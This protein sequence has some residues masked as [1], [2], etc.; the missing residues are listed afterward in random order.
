MDSMIEKTTI[1]NNKKV[2]YFHDDMNSPNDF[3]YQV[4]IPLTKN[5]IGFTK[6]ETTTIPPFE[7][8][9]DILFFDWGG[10]SL[11]NSMLNHFCRHI[12]KQAFDN[13]SRYYV[14][15]SLFTKNAMEDA[16]SEG[17]NKDIPNVFLTIDDFAKEFKQE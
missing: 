9:F 13:P 7:E 6:I 2:I 17:L 15:V 3:K 14:M 10:M 8:K 11:G 4:L 1:Y 12:I 5:H 16:I